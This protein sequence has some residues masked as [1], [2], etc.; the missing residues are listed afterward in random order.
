MVC[1]GGGTRPRL[2]RFMHTEM[3]VGQGRKA[4]FREIP[5]RESTEGGKRRAS[6]KNMERFP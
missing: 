5:V 2:E 1:G 3:G 4:P 6:M